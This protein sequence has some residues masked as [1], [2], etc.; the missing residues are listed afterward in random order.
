MKNG[1]FIIPSE[2]QSGTTDVGV[3]GLLYSQENVFTGSPSVNL[4]QRTHRLLVAITVYY[5]NYCLFYLSI[6]LHKRNK[7]YLSFIMI[8]KL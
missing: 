4:D 6:G 8:N 5:Y 2:T 3:H 1:V 7:R